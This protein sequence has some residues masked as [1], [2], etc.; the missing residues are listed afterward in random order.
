MWIINELL[1]NAEG[2][3]NYI[4]IGAA[5]ASK[6]KKHVKIQNKLGLN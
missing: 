2:S 5:V 3:L 6:E 1:T 4:R